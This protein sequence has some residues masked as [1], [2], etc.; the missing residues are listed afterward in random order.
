MNKNQWE[1]FFIILGLVISI[2]AAISQYLTKVNDDKE[3]E[4]KEKQLSEKLKKLQNDNDSLNNKSSKLLNLN[5]ELTR[6]NNLLSSQLG[7]NYENTIKTI[8]GAGIVDIY[9]V[10][11]NDKP[12]LVIKNIGNYPLYDV[13]VKIAPLK[14][15]KNCIRINS[16][17][18][19]ME[20]NCFMNA[21]IPLNTIN[22]I[23]DG[24]HAIFPLF[25][26]FKE[27]GYFTIDINTRKEKSL[28][29]IKM[30]FNEMKNEWKFRKAKFSKNEQGE[31]IN[32]PLNQDQLSAEEIDENFFDPNIKNL[33][34]DE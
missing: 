10:R 21:Q 18:K 16:G 5:E 4:L 33:P 3:S 28:F 6:Q 8:L 9:V 32:I 1:L 24:S 27:D 7:E 22:V 30:E 14:D 13:S 31:F 23:S 15:V 26:F 11:N 20:V 2:F 17:K 25:D 19:Y 12:A 29:F 34:F